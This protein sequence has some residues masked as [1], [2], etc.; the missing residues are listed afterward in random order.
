MKYVAPGRGGA[1]F[2]CVCA[3]VC[4]CMSERASRRGRERAE[5]S[6]SKRASECVRARRSERTVCDTAVSLVVADT[7][8]TLM[9]TRRTAELR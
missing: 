4:A 7:P 2:V 1:R 5:C 6:V 3:C 8:P 9:K